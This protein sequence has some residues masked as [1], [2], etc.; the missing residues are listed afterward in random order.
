[1]NRSELNQICWD[2]GQNV[3]NGPVKDNVARLVIHIEELT[4]Q[5]QERDSHIGQME[6]L[7]DEE[8]MNSTFGKDG[9]GN[10]YNR[11]ALLWESTF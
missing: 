4:K 7:M 6:E 11:R 3:E 8:D 2:L 9:G 1:M 10:L 5:I